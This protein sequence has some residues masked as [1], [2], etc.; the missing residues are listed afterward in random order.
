MLQRRNSDGND[1]ALDTIA[2][3]FVKETTNVRCVF[4]YMTTPDSV[5][6]LEFEF[7]VIADD[8]FWI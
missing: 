7:K 2:N 3:Y 4:E 6:L 1:A 5:V 8:N